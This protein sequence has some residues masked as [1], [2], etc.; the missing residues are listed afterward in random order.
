MRTGVLH[1]SLVS[2]FPFILPWINPFLINGWGNF[3]TREAGS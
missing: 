1:L 2:R 3:S